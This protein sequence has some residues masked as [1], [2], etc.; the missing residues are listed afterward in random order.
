MITESPLPA[1][2]TEATAD[3]AQLVE[4]GELSREE[5]M[6][7]LRTM[8]EIRSFEDKIYELYRAGA[9][10]GASHLS[11]GQEAVPAGA[12]A[13]I[14]PRDLVAS[15]HRGHGHCGAM[16]N[17]MAAGD[18][19]RQAHWNAM[20]AELFG[21]TTGYCRGRGGSMHIADVEHG[22]LGATGIVAGNIPIATGAALAE[23]LKG[24]DSVVL[25]FFGDGAANTGAFHEALNMGATLFG[26]LPVVYIC[27]N[28]LY[29][30]S[31]PFHQVGVDGAAFASKIPNVAQ[32]AAAYGMPGE[33]VDGQDVMAVREA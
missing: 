1:I 14:T 25:C 13:A 16:G 22:N 7:L 20:M 6:E 21:K 26:G 12:V 3:L 4:R 18:E 8:C 9:L 31:V 15:T 28:N 10:K 17:L 30:M 2:P 23:Q 5:L 24:S 11:A 29:G 33:I 32:R 19:E 27:E